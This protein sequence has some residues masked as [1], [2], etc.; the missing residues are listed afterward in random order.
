MALFSSLLVML[1]LRIKIKRGGG[2]NDPEIGLKFV[3]QKNA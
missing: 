1:S 3:M 2:E